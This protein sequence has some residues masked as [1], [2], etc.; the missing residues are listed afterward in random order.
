MVVENKSFAEA[1]QIKRLGTIH[2]GHTLA[3]VANP[4]KG[5][6]TNSFTVKEASFTSTQSSLPPLSNFQPKWKKRMNLISTNNNFSQ[7]SS[8]VQSQ[9][10]SP[11][12]SNGS[13]FNFVD[14]PVSNATNSNFIHSLSDQITFVLLISSDFQTSS[15]SALKSLIESSLYTFLTLKSD[16]D[17]TF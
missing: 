17:K 12:S 4:F 14:Q 11:A 9:N 10:I 6:F 5:V 13:Y 8:F 15:P 1:I 16:D 7:Y 3:D 2:K